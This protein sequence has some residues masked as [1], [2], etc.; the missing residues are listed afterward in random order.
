M[1][2]GKCRQ[3]YLNNKIKKSKLKKN[4][5]V[6]PTFLPV[7]EGGKGNAI[8]NIIKSTAKNGICVVD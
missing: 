1:G 5:L 8:K 2:A 3:L 4:E 6:D 7:L